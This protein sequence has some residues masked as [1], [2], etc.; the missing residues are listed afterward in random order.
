MLYII[1]KKSGLHREIK[2]IKNI[3][4][5][6]SKKR[7]YFCSDSSNSGS[8]SYSS[9]SSDSD[10]YEERHPPE[11][12]GINRFDHA[13]NNNI[14]INKNQRNDATEY[15]PKFDNTFGLPRRTK[16]NLP[17]VNVSLR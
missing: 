6:N 16:E 4:S 17:V 14:N 8:D 11:L 1:T 12:K 5:K 13:V 9:L 7:R 15:E 3:R 2:K 10:L